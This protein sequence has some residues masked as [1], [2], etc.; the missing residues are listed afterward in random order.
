LPSKLTSAN[1]GRSGVSQYLDSL[2]VDSA[3]NICVA[4]PGGS[5]VLV[6]PPEGGAP[7]IVETPDFLTTN[8]CFGGPDLRTAYITLGSTGQLAKMEWPVTGL[9]LA[10]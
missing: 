2:A 5:A 10:Y 3:G 1:I 8:I 6:F 4:S 7:K 9:K